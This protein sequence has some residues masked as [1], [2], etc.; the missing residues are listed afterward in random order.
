MVGTLT[1][2]FHIF[3]DATEGAVGL[4]DLNAAINL[5]QPHDHDDS[6]DEVRPDD[7]S[8]TGMERRGRDGAN[9]YMDR[10]AGESTDAQIERE[11]R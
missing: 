2:F 10:E 1:S 5:L 6:S 7:D 3:P 9:R 8:D 11:D 4:A